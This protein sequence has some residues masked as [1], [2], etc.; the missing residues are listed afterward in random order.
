MTATVAGTPAREALQG[1]ADA[2]AAAGVESP[3]LDAELLLCEATAWER[4]QLAAGPETPVPAAAG[5]RFAAAIRRRLRR[6]PLAY[7][8]GRKGFRGIEPAVDPRALIPRPE[9]ELLVEVAVELGP[10]SVVDVGTGSGAVALAVAEELPGCEVTATDTSAAA[11]ELAGENAA[12]LG[13]GD[14]VRFEAGTLPE[15]GFD[16]V[17]ANLPYVRDA[18][19]EGLAPEIREFEPREALLGGADGLDAIRAL[20]ADVGERP[21]GAIALEVGIGQ[22]AEVENL[23]LGAGFEAVDRRQDLAGVERVVV[24]R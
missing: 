22:A 2:L 7:I 6:E 8:S 13:L 19:W 23:V 17:L 16:L 4:A 18:E 14:R 3:R 9:T 5:R 10:G 12:R 15:G 11:L 1:A 24:G 20:L 21:A